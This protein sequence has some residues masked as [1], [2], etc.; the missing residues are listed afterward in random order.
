[1]DR[2][3]SGIKRPMVQRK[4]LRNILMQIWTF[5]I[6]VI[7]QMDKYIVLKQLSTHGREKLFN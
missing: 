7:F 3:C 2:L 4:C 5:K 6:K 1:M